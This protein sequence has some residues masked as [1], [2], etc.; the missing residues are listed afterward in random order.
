M[1]VRAESECQLAS[2]ASEAAQLN[3]CRKIVK[4]QVPFHHAKKIKII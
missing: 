1:E 2:E 3:D 4:K